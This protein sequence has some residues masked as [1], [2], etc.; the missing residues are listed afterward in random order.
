MNA[1]SISNLC[2]VYKGGKKALADLSIEV[3]EGEIFALLGP[4][5]AGKSTLIN[6]L[7][8]LLPPTSGKILIMGKN[9]YTEQKL[10]RPLISCVAQKV[11][12]D[13]HLSLRENMLFQGRLYGLDKTTA[14]K[15]MEALITE[16]GLN[17]Y[18]KDRVRT[19]SGGIKRRLDIAM[20]MMSYPKILFLDEPTVGMDIESRQAMWDVV[21]EIK[22]DYGTSILLTTH[23]LEEANMLS[24]TICIMQN[25][26]QLVQDT[27]ENLRQ[28]TR[29]NI[30]RIDLDPSENQQIIIK[31]IS[32]LQF[33]GGVRK[34]QN[35]IY[36]ST[37]NP[38]QDFRILNQLLMDK[39]TR[40]SSIGVVTPS[41]DD[42]FLSLTQ[43]KG[44]Q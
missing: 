7:T 39:Q 41:L 6:I 36:A 43:K 44:R 21:K 30:I 16:F 14:N 27:P 34:D 9:L 26:H 24:D 18:E 15:R 1:I 35:I 2:K 25:G 17:K 42:V 40:Y 11:S 29:K 12:I 22:T 37:Q 20:S 23:Y 13:D 28:H 32:E 33:I 19:Y 38:M 10:I 3:Q 4:N 5:G 8:T 31:W